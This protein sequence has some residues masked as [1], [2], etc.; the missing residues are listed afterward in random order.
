MYIHM[1]VMNVLN[2]L[3]A[4][5]EFNFSPISPPK[6]NILKFLNPIPL[7]TLGWTTKFQ[8]IFSCVKSIK[9]SWKS[10]SHVW[11]PSHLPSLLSSGSLQG[12][13]GGVGH[14]LSCLS[15]LVGGG[16]FQCGLCPPS[17]LPGPHPS[18]AEHQEGMLEKRDECLFPPLCTWTHRSCASL[19]EVDRPSN[20]LGPKSVP[21]SGSCSLPHAQFPTWDSLSP[22]RLLENNTP[23]ITCITSLDYYRPFVYN[24]VPIVK[25]SRCAITSVISKS[26]LLLHMCSVWKTF[27]NHNKMLSNRTIQ[28][29]CPVQQQHVWGQES[30]KRAFAYLW[31]CLLS[32]S[33]TLMPF[34]CL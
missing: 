20:C 3:S 15:N 11:W 19:A 33:V 22:T 32:S 24:H 16:V 1:Y 7:M 17:C 12:G 14:L 10:S 5:S 34:A 26:Y 9:H 25:S 31:S 29:Y 21:F 13:E 2:V 27:L 30:K 4:I 8:I 23:A 6:R 18:G 28:R